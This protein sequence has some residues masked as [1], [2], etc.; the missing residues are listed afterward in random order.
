ME[1]RQDSPLQACSLRCAAGVPAS[2][3]AAPLAPEQRCT[4]TAA[5]RC[6]TAGPAQP[7]GVGSSWNNGCALEPHRPM[8]R[9][10]EPPRQTCY[11][12]HV[13]L[14]AGPCTKTALL[15][16]SAGVWAAG[17]QQCACLQRAGCKAGCAHNRTPPDL[18]QMCRPDCAPCAPDLEGCRCAL[19]P[20]RTM[21]QARP[22]ATPEK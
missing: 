6:R 15:T 7:T 17:C 13:P 20:R 22:S 2:C 21:V 16:A 4:S 18:C 1:Q 3:T 10:H 19:A 9:A 11:G 12:L 5:A 14:M 8:A